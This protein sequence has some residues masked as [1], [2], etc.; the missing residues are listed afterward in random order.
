V[1]RGDEIAELWRRRFYLG[2]FFWRHGPGFAEIRDRRMQRTA[3]LIIEDP[4]HLRWLDAL[5][6]GTEKTAV[7]GAVLAEFAAKNLL[8]EV[9]DCVWLTPYRIRRWPSHPMAV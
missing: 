8:H 9:G 3:R 4:A 5:S 1:S 6:R 7:P 2:K